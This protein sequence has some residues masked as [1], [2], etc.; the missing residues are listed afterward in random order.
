MNVSTVV[1][2]LLFIVVGWPRELGNLLLADG[3]LSWD[4]IASQIPWDIVLIQAGGTAISNAAFV[5]FLA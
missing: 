2:S 1:F 5:R 3:T 4:A